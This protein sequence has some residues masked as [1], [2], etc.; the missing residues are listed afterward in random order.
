MQ[1]K[2]TEKTQLLYLKNRYNLGFYSHIK[3]RCLYFILYYI[4]NNDQCICIEHIKYGKQIQT[5]VLNNEVYQS[6]VTIGRV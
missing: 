1:G 2:S 3:F 5:C 4:I 6:L